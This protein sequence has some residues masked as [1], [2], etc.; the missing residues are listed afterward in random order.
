M[1]LKVGDVK[2]VFP[3]IMSF[4]L[5][6]KVGSKVIEAAHCKVTQEESA[7]CATAVYRE[8]TLVS[9]LE[10]ESERSATAVYTA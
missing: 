10:R 3:C 5:G 4:C 1:L 7:S 6:P 8:D 2:V 9:R